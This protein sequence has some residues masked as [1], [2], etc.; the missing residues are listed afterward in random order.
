[1][2]KIFF[3]GISIQVVCGVLVALVWEVPFES[4]GVFNFVVGWVIVAGLMPEAM[5]Y[6]IKLLT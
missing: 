1:M 3:G 2:K 6:M 4:V 5:K